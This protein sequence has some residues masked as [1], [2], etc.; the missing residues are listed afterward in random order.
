MNR[1]GSEIVDGKIEMKE[2]PTAEVLAQAIESFLPLGNIPSRGYSC[3]PEFKKYIYERFE[4][5]LA[6]T[7][8]IRCSNI[9]D[10]RYASRYRLD[11]KKYNQFVDSMI[12]NRSN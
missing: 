10:A 6:V 8:A 2:M 1:K 5:K 3:I 11:V 9:L 12:R 4:S 7:A